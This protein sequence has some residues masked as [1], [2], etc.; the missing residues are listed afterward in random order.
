M[1]RRA[2]PFVLLLAAVACGKKGPPPKPWKGGAIAHGGAGSPPS[3]SDGCR[4]AVDAALQGL[5]GGGDPLDA[6]AARGH[7]PVG[8]LVRAPDGRF[9][10]ALSTG[11]WI[12]LLA[13]RVGDVPIPGAGIYVTADGAAAATGAGELIIDAM[14]TRDALDAVHNGAT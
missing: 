8:L 14:L 9:A 6:A 3:R 2:V 12:L 13:G 4:K 10:A 1:L 7:D 11:G 5:D